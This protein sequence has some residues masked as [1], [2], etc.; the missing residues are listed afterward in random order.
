[1]NARKNTLPIL[2]LLFVFF[3]LFVIIFPLELRYELIER[4]VEFLFRADIAGADAQALLE[5]VV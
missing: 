4:L 3:D 1:M 2:F 5:S